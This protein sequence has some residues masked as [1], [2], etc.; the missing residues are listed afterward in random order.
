LM[1]ALDEPFHLAECSHE[2]AV[3]SCSFTAICPV[4][5]AIANVH[6]RIRDMLRT[7]TLAEVFRPPAPEETRIYGLE[8]LTHAASGN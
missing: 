1:E 6:A 4:K 7:V 2:S 5:G 3:S 8:L